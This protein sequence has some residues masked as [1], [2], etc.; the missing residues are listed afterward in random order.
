MAIGGNHARRTRERPFPPQVEAPTTE[1]KAPKP[2]GVDEYMPVVKPKAKAKA[3]AKK[4]A[5][6]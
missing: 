3:K 5:K 1:V 2:L 4:K 6:S